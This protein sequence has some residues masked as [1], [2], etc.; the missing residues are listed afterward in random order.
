MNQKDSPCGLAIL[1]VGTYPKEGKT[2][3]YEYS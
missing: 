1:T 3:V 2:Q